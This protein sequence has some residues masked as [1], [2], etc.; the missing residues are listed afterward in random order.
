MDAHDP[1]EAL[2]L[3][4]LA[5]IAGGPRPYAEVMEAWRTSCPRLS[6]WEEATERGFVARLR[7]EGRTLVA[8]TG[9]GRSFLLDHGRLPVPVPGPETA[10]HTTRH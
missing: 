3:D 7:V 8:L 6:V 2:L 10:A 1:V 5:W 9:E 4:M